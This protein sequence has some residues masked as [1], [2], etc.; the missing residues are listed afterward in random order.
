MFACAG[1]LLPLAFLL[2]VFSVAAF[3]QLAQVKPDAGSVLEGLKQPPPVPKAAPEVLPRVEEPRPALGAP[4]LKVTVTAFKISGNTLFSE[5]V[6]LEQV[7]E[8]VGKEQTIDGLNDAATKVRAYYRERGYFL[9]QA[10]LPQQEIKA[11]VVEIAVIEARVGKV[12]VDFKQG[13][14]FSERLVRGI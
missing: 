5:A 7:K 8:F 14:R 4:G 11:G 12:A 6:L 1:R 13:S 9:A 2:S 10:Y 3:G